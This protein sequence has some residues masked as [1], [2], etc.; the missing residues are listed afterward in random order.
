VWLLQGWYE[1]GWWKRR[2]G[3]REWKEPTE[4][5]GG[6]DCTDEEVINFLQR[7][8]VLTVSHF[9]VLS[10]SSSGV[11]SFGTVRRRNWYKAWF[12]M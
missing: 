10:E 3:S 12:I 7:Q 2:D 11:T 1:D 4:A 9:P 6:G 8:R 5:V